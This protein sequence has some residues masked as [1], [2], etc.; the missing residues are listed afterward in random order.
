MQQK[1]V[2]LITFTEERGNSN[3]KYRAIIETPDEQFHMTLPAV[4][5]FQAKLAQMQ[6]D[7]GIEAKHMVPVKYKAGDDAD[8]ARKMNLLL[9][10]M[11]GG[12]L[13]ALYRSL[14]GKTG[15]GSKGSKGSSKGSGS[16]PFGGGGGG[17]MGDLMGMSKSGATIFGVDKKI[18]TRF[19]HVA[20]M[21]N[22]K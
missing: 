7:M 21:E 2:T 14:H 19:K 11:F 15:T 12:V 4:E 20:G 6:H 13:L 22:A 18:R 17:G 1:R 16:G 8:E 9:A 3:F 5:N 10:L